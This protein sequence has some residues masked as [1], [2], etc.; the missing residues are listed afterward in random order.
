MG[1]VPIASLG[2]MLGVDT[3]VTHS[4]ITIA[5]TFKAQDFWAEGRTVEK[6]GL[7]GMSPREIGT[8][9]GQADYVLPVLL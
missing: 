4:L 3:P 5:S 8:L 6:L 7:A 1:L 2:D 9:V